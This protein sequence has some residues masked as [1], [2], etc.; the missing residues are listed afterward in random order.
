M[1]QEWKPRENLAVDVF[2]SHEREA[3]GVIDDPEFTNVVAQQWQIAVVCRIL[4][5]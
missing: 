3:Q 1:L 4:R 2:T 5:N